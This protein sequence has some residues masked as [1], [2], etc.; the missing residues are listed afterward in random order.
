MC[1][2]RVLSTVSATSPTCSPIE[3]TC[4]AAEVIAS[5]STLPRSMFFND[6]GSETLRSVFRGRRDSLWL[7]RATPPAI[8]A[9]AAPPANKG[10]FAFE[11][12]S[13]TLPPAF[14]TEPLE[15]VVPRGW[16]EVR[17]PLERGVLLAFD[18]D[19]LDEL[20]VLEEV[21][22]PFFVLDR[23]ALEELFPLLDLFEPE[24]L[25]V[26]RPLEDRVVWAIVIASL[27]CLASC[28][29]RTGGPPGL[30]R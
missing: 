5:R 29:F 6:L 7:F 15:E 20:E 30:T 1:F 10:V 23:E 3:R 26:D 28:A 17:L 8:P 12:S 18:R 21:E 24:R 2:L 22:A 16:E 13:A 25:R 9:M 11:A 27:G 4:R 14:A 19:V